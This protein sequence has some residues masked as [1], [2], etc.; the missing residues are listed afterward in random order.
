MIT[1]DEKP[2]T[3]HTTNP[4]P[5]IGYCP[6]KPLKWSRAE[7]TMADIAPTVLSYMGLDIPDDMKG[8][9]ML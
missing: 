5:F 8:K 6:E 1:E 7:A 3:S 2:V 9:S 4:V